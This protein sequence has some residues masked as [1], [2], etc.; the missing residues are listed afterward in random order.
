VWGLSNNTSQLAESTLSK[1]N[2]ALVQYMT[3]F[4]QI[5]SLSFDRNNIFYLLEI[6]SAFMV[7]YFRMQTRVVLPYLRQLQPPTSATK[8]SGRSQ[9]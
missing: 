9:A 8:A 6:Y 4:C 3:V 1:M 5:F 2:N 7:I